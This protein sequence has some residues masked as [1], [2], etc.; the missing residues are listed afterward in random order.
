MP[1][2]PP[3]PYVTNVTLKNNQIV[4]TVK[5]D[6]Y[7]PGEPLEISGHAT[8]N[9]GAFAVFYDLQPVP[10]P[11]PDG[12]AY[13]YVKAPQ[14]QEFEQGH[15]VTVVLR[16]ARVWT[17]VLGEEQP[18]QGSAT[19]VGPQVQGESAGEG[20]NWNTVKAVTYAGPSSTG[21]AGQTTAGS[22]AS[23]PGGT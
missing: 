12:T 6:D 16:A 5:V 23:F 9:N 18:E 19:V 7:P 3:R 13:M 14:S 1:P 17:T 15:D 4:L 8:Q 21:H 22:E 2:P 20:V 10:E 11:N